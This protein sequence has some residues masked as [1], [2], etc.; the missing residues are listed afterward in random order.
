[1]KGG[2]TKYRKRDHI[3][4]CLEERVESHTGPGFD[5]II[6]VHES[7]PDS[8]LSEMDTSYE[9]L[10]R[11]VGAPLVIE[12]IT[13]GVIDALE[14]NRRLA[15]AAKEYGVILSVGSQRAAL[16]DPGLEHTFRVVRDAAPEA[17]ILANIGCAQLLQGDPVEAAERAVEMIEADGLTV[18]LNPLQEAVQPEG[19]PYLKGINRELGRL[20]RELKVPLIVKETGAGISAETAIQLENLGVEF[21]DVAG[22]GGTSW[23]GVEYYRALSMGDPLR[24]KLGE[25]FWDWGIPTAVSLIEVLEFTSMKAVASGGVRNGVDLAKALALG[26]EAGGMALPFLRAAVESRETVSSLIEEII[27]EL[28]LA[29][30]LTGSRN[31]RELR[32]KPLVILGR[33]GEWLTLRRVDPGKYARRSLK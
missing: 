33:T 30:F 3:R 18:H 8:D 1:M 17:V 5:D 32:C 24:A 2:E 22:L 27:R 9:F 6:L 19:E 10:G 16:E 25:G 15:E 28:K 20:T 21:V 11:R 29:M 7:L 23:A 13:G 12:P 31:I 4:I 26:A 14:I